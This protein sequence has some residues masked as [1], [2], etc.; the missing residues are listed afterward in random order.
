MPGTARASSFPADL[1]AANNR[2]D[3]LAKELDQTNARIADLRGQA[4]CDLAEAGA[5][6][7]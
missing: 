3:M 1:A 4:R 6:A 5:D 7:G 2:S